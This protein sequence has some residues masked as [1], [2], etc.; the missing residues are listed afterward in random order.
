MLGIAVLGAAHIGIQAYHIGYGLP[1]A[2]RIPWLVIVPVFAGFALLHALY[3]LGCRRALLLLAVTCT[4]GFLFEFFGVRTGVIFGRYVYTDVLGPKILSTVPV[5]IPFAYFM[6]LYPSYVMTNLILDARPE[7]NGHTV[8]RAVWAS[9]LT[10]LVM[11]AWDL[12]ND[13][14][15]VDPVGAWIWLDGGPYFGIPLR[16]FRGWI[17]VSI[18]IVF[19]YRYLERFLRFEPYG[20]PFR[21]IMLAP[22]VTYGAF[23]LS[24]C[25]I[26]YPP[27]TRVIPPFAMGIPMIAAAVRLF[28]RPT[29]AVSA[30]HAAASRRLN[31]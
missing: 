11:T 13:P 16:N 8:L 30:A 4:S 22:I 24:D 15:M 20:R 27:P 17:L 18:T 31:V 25:L 12:S 21:W 26:G 7:A 23:A 2:Q 14:L 28:D 5:I 6:M 9:M 3:T 19:V 10:G 29:A 1:P